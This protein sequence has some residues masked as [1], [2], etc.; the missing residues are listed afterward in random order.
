MKKLTTVLCAAFLMFFAATSVSA[1]VRFAAKAGLNLANVS[2]DDVGNNK[3]LPTFLVGGQAEFGL[4]DNLGLG[5]GLQLCGKGFKVEDTGF[6]GKAK[7]LYLQVPVQFFY[8][9]NGFF[10]GVGPYVG[11]GIAGKAESDGDSE[12]IDFGNGTED[13]WAPLDF[14]AGLELG[15]QFGS[16]RATASYNL[17]F[18]NVVPG[19]YADVF[20]ISIKNTVIGIALAYL[21][22]GNN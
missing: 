13:D 9:N 14:G 17:G 4:S 1:Q 22:G 7:P 2:G 20:D 6:E 16:V 19:D 8:Q 12:S 3:I 18:A 21:F 5:V 15:Y 11:F 10:A